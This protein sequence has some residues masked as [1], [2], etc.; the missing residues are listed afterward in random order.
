METVLVGGS[1]NQHNPSS[2]IISEDLK[3][4]GEPLLSKLVDKEDIAEE[5]RKA[6]LEAIKRISGR[7]SAISIENKE[8]VDVGHLTAR[9][10]DPLEY[11]PECI[12]ANLAK[13]N[14]DWRKHRMLTK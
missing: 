1:G 14:D 2:E 5:A 8:P 11:G 4:E 9:D 6:T 3:Y 7:T 10:L 13:E 12:W